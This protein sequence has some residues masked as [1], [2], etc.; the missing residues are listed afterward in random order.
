M[1]AV[2]I[3]Y[4]KPMLVDRYLIVTA[5]ALALAA[6]YAIARLGRLAGAAALVVLVAVG[7]VHVRDWYHS[8]IPEDWRGAVAHATVVGHPG[9]QILVYP[10]FMGDPAVYYARSSIDLSERLSD[11]RAQVIAIS[12]DAPAVEQWVSSGGYRI[13]DRTRFGSID[14]WRVARTGSG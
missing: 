14:V 8:P 9:E 1:G 2:A 10:S 4:F 6:S 12:Q 11:D 5:P 13:I 3:S 7:L